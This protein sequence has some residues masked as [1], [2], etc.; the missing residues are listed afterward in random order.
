MNCP[1]KTTGTAHGD[2]SKNCRCGQKELSVKVPA[3]CTIDGRRDKTNLP[4]TKDKTPKS[5]FPINQDGGSKP[6]NLETSPGSQKQKIG[7]AAN[8]VIL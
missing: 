2:F 8:S 7:L 5:I 6:R 1:H 3:G 4:K